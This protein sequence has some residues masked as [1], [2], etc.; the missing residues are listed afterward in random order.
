MRNL[1]NIIP[2]LRSTLLMKCIDDIEKV[3]SEYFKEAFDRLGLKRYEQ[4]DG[5]EMGALIKFKNDFF[6]L[7]LVN[8]RGLIEA[9]LSPLYGD[10]LF[11]GIELYNSLVTLSKSSDILSKFERRKILGTKFDYKSQATFLLDNVE[12][13]KSS[14]DK[15]HYKDTLGQIDNLGRERFSLTFN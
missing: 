8:D 9:D 2:D 11:I 3:F 5:Q 15:K 4:M 6:K 13:L 1:L 7:Q 14:L 12:K 10:E